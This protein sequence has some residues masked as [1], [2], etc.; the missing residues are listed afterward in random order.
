MELRKVVSKDLLKDMSKGLLKDLLKDMSKGLLKGLLKDLSKVV[1]KDLSTQTR[2]K[3]PRPITQ[4]NKYSSHILHK[5]YLYGFDFTYRNT[6]VLLVVKLI[7][8]I[9]L[10]TILKTT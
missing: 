8:L 2:I 6:F 3:A 1:V 5:L 7:Q 4:L 9:I 10:F